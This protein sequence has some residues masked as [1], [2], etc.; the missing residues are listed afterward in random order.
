MDHRTSVPVP[1]ERAFARFTDMTPW[2]P[3]EYTWAQRTLVELAVEPREGG[4]CYE[5]GPHGFRCDWGRVVT[6]EPPHR[7]A[8]T[9]QI[10]PQRVPQPDPARASLV[11]A[12]FAPEGDGTL[13]TLTHRHFTRHGEDAESY[14]TAM[15]SDKGWPLLLERY[16]ASF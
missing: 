11:D 8:F 4:H 7:I 6:C 13:V 14:E 15:N 5:V 1:P 9:W 2:W 12:R 16:A 3:A 10:S